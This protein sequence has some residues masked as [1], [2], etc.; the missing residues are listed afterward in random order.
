PQ[1]LAGDD[2]AALL[3]LQLQRLPAATCAGF[4]I[5]IVGVHLKDLVSLHE[6]LPDRLGGQLNLS[7]L[8]GLYQQA[9][10]LR[11]LQQA[12]PPFAANKD[13]VHLLTLSLD[14]YYTDDEIYELSYARE[15]RCPKSLPATPF[16]PPVVV[17]WARGPGTGPA[18]YQQTR[19]ADGGGE[20]GAHP[21][22]QPPG[23]RADLPPSQPGASSLRQGPSWVQGAFAM[24]VGQVC[25]CWVCP[26]VQ[27]LCVC[28][29]VQ[30]Q[31]GVS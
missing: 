28:H 12:A 16:K 29:G 8:Q 3:L 1:T 26:A 10:E 20:P 14:L 5:P 31:E 22:A 21:S 11:A 24:C 2:R 18:H 19:P 4:K 30:W 6:A 17:E 7:K 27:L 9:L 15:P 13:L 23:P 25:S